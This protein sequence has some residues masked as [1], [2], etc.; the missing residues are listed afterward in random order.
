MNRNE[1]INPICFSHRADFDGMCSAALVRRYFNGEVEIHP[2]DYGDKEISGTKSFFDAFKVKNRTV[3]ICDFS[4]KP[5]LFKMICKVAKNVVWLDHHV[6]AVQDILKCKWFTEMRYPEDLNNQK[7][8]GHHYASEEFPFSG[9]YLTWCFFFK[10]DGSFMQ[11]WDECP[12]FIKN[13]AIYDTWKF[14]SE[15]EKIFLTKFQLGMKAAGLNWDTVQWWDALISDVGDIGVTYDEINMGQNLVAMINEYGNGVYNFNMNNQFARM[16]K[17]AYPVKFKVNGK[18]L[19]GLALNVNG[20]NSEVFEP[21]YDPTKHDFCIEYYFTG[22]IWQFSV[23][24]F[25]DKIGKV[26]AVDVIRSFCD[27][28]GH[29]GAAGGSSDKLPK[30]L[31]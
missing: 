24:V 30:E 1:F 16:N 23:Y 6:S 22:K 19:R 20:Y 10:D 7:I 5:A 15:D 13:I 29:S 12:E 25:P 28:G 31:L 17:N 3:I 4:F 8:F 21:I 18:N 26:N 2:V 14:M 9:A 11:Y 27:G